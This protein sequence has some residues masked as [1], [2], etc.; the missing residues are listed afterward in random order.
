MLMHPREWGQK[1]Q[2]REGGE[3]ED[4]KVIEV[5]KSEDNHTLSPNQSFRKQ[6]FI[7]VF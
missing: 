6:N 1:G 4:Q 7:N 2:R 5:I 3:R